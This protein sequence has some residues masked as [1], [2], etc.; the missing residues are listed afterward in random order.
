MTNAAGVDPQID[1][2]ERGEQLKREGVIIR[3]WD[4]MKTY[5][6][7]DQTIHAVSLKSKDAKIL[8]T[9]IGSPAFLV[10][11]VGYS[12]ETPTWWEKTLYRGDSYEFHRARSSPGRLIQLVAK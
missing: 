11:A 1:K 12:G 7:G 8:N 10:S 4:L 2:L 6:M 3:T 5:V 9:P